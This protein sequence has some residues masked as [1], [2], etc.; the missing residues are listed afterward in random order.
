M[1]NHNTNTNKSS[2]AIS[3]SESKTKKKIARKVIF[4]AAYGS[5]LSITQMASRCPDSKIVGT[6]KIPNYKLVFRYHAD[7][8]PCEGS[9][10]PVLIW[11]ISEADEKRLDRYEGVKGGYY[12]QETVSVFMEGQDGE[13]KAMAYIMNKQDNVSPPDDHYYQIIAEGYE[14]FGFDKE[15]LAQTLREAMGNTQKA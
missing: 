7:I 6:G 3:S 12:H 15:I 8:E 5:N 9:Y 14:R 1:N 10:V 11:K 2:S 4:Y 13:K